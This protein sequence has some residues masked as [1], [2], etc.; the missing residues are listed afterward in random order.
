MQNKRDQVQ[1][2]MFLMG[3]LTSGMLR[4]D[5]DAPESPQ[6]RTN[7]G[8]AIGIIIALLVAGGAF[9]LGLFNPGK[10]DSWQTSGNLIVDKGT[11]ARYLYLDGRL[12]PVRNYASAKLL[13]GADLATTTVSS[14]SLKDTPRGTPIGIGGAPDEL[15]AAGDLSGDPW[16]VCATPAEPGVA[17]DRTKAVTTLAVA[18]ESDGDQ[19]ADD[20]GLLAAGPDGTGYLLW[21]GSRL[22]L[23]RKS[24]A[25]EA[26]GYASVDPVP[27]S[28]AF[29]NALPAGPD[30]A[31]PNVPGRGTPGPRLDGRETTVGQ[32]F[33]LAVPGAGERHYVLREDG[34]APLTATELALVL[35]D[36]KTRADAY[37]G[38]SPAP[39]TLSSEGLKGAL[40]PGESR[41]KGPGESP[42][43]PPKAVT[44]GD[45]RSPC[46]R[47]SPGDKKG[48]HV[49]VTL[50]STPGLGP[51]AQHASGAAAAACLPVDRITVPPGRGA[52]VRA[53]GA[54]GGKVGST[55]YL[56][57]ETGVKYR[58]A[59]T[60][61]VEALGYKDATPR[62]MPLLMLAMLPS[63]PDLY[64]EAAESGRSTVTAPRCAWGDERERKEIKGENGAEGGEGAEGS[65]GV[66]GPE[67][68]EEAGED[69][70]GRESKEKAI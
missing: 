39:V 52:L 46:A 58:L 28:A 36:P 23:D 65:E 12:R 9:V 48:V 25:P 51:V 13:A 42:Q 6:G 34:L 5:P 38:A 30:L 19:L 40:A 57:T 17:A 68:S 10:Q 44:V 54:A 22:R 37:G 47:I 29:L 55:V 11:G 32:V 69:T 3:R 8:V 62:E 20:E 43:S 41:T 2:H 64:P 56:V 50:T 18:H 35:A 53:V 61:A 26:L 16:Q 33:E 31:A 27:V 49:D 59:G 45:D 24:G 67:G 70:E 1:A 7:R 14:A 21:Q 15:P 63:G 60:T 66:E 4:A